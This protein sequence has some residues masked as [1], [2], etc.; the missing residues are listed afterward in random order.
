[1]CSTAH[2]CHGCRYVQHWD[3]TDAVIVV[4]QE[5]DEEGASGGFCNVE[6]DPAQVGAPDYSLPAGNVISSVLTD[7]DGADSH[8]SSHMTSQFTANAES[9]RLTANALSSLLHPLPTVGAATGCGAACPDAMA[10]QRLQPTDQWLPMTSQTSSD[11]PNAVAPLPAVA[12]Q[13]QEVP[14]APIA[15]QEWEGHPLQELSVVSSSAAGTQSQMQ[16]DGGATTEQRIQ[17]RSEGRNSATVSRRENELSMDFDLTDALMSKDITKLSRVDSAQRR[18][19]QLS[20]QPAVPS[21][22][23]DYALSMALGVPLPADQVFSM[24]FMCFAT[25]AIM[26][27]LAPGR[28]A[29]NSCGP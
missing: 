10:P 16:A 9:S 2:F 18:A 19:P 12:L 25:R 13:P 1:M 5:D 17:T 15:V 21:F 4:K 11:P 27:L 29:L 23:D 6:A 3:L 28:L 24:L 7:G 22:V 14:A 26:I 8:L 20:E